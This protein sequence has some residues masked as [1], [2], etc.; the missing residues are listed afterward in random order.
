MEHPGGVTPGIAD[1]LKGRKSMQSVV[2]IGATQGT[3][4]A[5]AAEYARRG[6]D[7]VITGRSAERAVEQLLGSRPV[8]AL[9]RRLARRPSCVRR[10]PSRD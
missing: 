9:R 2:I 4:K 5:L 1:H 3:G 10:S 7:V 8:R 6:A